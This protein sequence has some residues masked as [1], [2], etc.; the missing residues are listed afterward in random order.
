LNGKENFIKGEHIN[1]DSKNLL[2]YG[3]S[4]LIA[5]IGVK[6]LVIV[7]TQD[8]IL[9]CNRDKAQLVSDVVKKL[10]ETGRIQHL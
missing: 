10:E 1:F 3:G 6:N 4:K 8:A 7:D 9:I 5:T 2:V